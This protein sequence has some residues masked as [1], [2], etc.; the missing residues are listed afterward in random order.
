M[1]SRCGAVRK[2]GL[3]GFEQIMIDNRRVLARINFVGVRDL[4]NIETIFSRWAKGPM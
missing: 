4:T 2:F 3:H 1:P